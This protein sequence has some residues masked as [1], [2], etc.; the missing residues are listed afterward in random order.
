MENNVNDNL[1]T[2]QTQDPVVAKVKKINYHLSV[3]IMSLSIFG[4]FFGYYAC[5]VYY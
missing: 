2:P 5:T 3:V 4:L 1:I